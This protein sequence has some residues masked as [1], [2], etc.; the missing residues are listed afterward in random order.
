MLQQHASHMISTY[1]TVLQHLSEIRQAAAGKSP[2]GAAL[3]PL[4]EPERA[5]LAEML[6]TLAA[7]LQRLVRAFIGADHGA[8]AE[9]QGPSATRMW[10]S[11]L[12]CTVEEL[13]SDLHPATMQRR[14]G[15]MDRAEADRLRAEVEALLRFVRDVMAAS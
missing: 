7:R 2:A 15:E 6:D 4:P 11:I 1:T 13:V 10:I 5:R 9:A 14:Y 8:E 12:M 3:V